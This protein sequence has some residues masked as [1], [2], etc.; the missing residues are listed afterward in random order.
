MCVGRSNEVSKKGDF[1]KFDLGNESI[2]V[3]RDDN[4]ILHGLFNV[5]RHRG[6]RICNDIKGKF[7]NTIQCKYHGWTYNLEGSLV[8]APNMDEVENFDKR[9]LS[10]VSSSSRPISLNL[11]A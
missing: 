8:G 2:I 4:N 7:S 6:T 10:N 1:I 9:F 5:C 3:V 11:S